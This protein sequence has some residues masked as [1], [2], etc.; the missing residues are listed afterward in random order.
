VITEHE[1]KECMNAVRET[2]YRLMEGRI[3]DDRFELLVEARKVV[4]GMISELAE[5]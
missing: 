5:D 2:L 1:I 3:A 4:Q